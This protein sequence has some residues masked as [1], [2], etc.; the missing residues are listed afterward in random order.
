[1]YFVCFKGAVRNERMCLS[2]GKERNGE[3]EYTTCLKECNLL[4]I[5]MKKNDRIFLLI[6]NPFS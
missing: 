2:E 3:Y 6:S 1:M 4:Y 5:F